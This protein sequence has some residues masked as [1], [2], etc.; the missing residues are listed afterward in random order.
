VC[1]GRIEGQQGG[2]SSTS[3]SSSRSEQGFVCMCNKLSETRHK[4]KLLNAFGSGP[5]M[6]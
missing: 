3:S 1:M 6:M 5:L 4:S 2:S